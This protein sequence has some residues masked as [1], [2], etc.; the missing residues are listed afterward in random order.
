MVRGCAG[1]FAV[2]TRQPE[3]FP[4]AMLALSS[5]GVERA[6]AD[7]G[8]RSTCALRRLSREAV[9]RLQWSNVHDLS[10]GCA[11]GKGK[12]VSTP[13]KLR[14]DFRSRAS[15]AGELRELSSSGTRRSRAFDT[16][17]V[18][19]AQELLRVSCTARAD[20]WTRHLVLR[21]LP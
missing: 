17:R 19:R 11:S 4:F 6:A 20:K 16:S 12:A 9:C 18:Q 3:P 10:Y 15:P 21:Y 8:S 1:L 2:Q 14:H 13:C 7:A 5:T